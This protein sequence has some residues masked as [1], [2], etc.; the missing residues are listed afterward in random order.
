[1]PPTMQV[2]SSQPVLT[3]FLIRV[4]MPITTAKSIAQGRIVSMMS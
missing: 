3:F 1:M 4:Y 2:S